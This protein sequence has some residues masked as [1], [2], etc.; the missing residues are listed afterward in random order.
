M[1]IPRRGPLKPDY[2][3][4]Q[5]GDI[6][7]KTGLLDGIRQVHEAGIIRRRRRNK[8]DKL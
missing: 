6:K 4:Y 1:I 3:V 7:T 2:H 8:L 5:T